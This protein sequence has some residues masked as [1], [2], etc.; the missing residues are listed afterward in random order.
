MVLTWSSNVGGTEEVIR[1]YASK[2]EEAGKA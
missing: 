1:N 2:K